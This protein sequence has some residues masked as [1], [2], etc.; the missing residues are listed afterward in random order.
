[1]G[2][3][4]RNDPCTCGSGRKFKQCCGRAARTY[5]DEER[6]NVRN[7]L[8]QIPDQDPDR[9]LEVRNEVFEGI[10]HEDEY[11][12]IEV[13]EWALSW[14]VSEAPS[15][16]AFS[17]DMPPAEA[18]YFDLLY[19]SRASLYE[20]VRVALPQVELRDAFD[21]TRLVVYQPGEDHIEVGHWIAGRVLKGPT[22]LPLV[23]DRPVLGMLPTPPHTPM[24]TY[25]SVQLADIAPEAARAR[26]AIDLMFVYQLESGYGPSDEGDDGIV[27]Q[28][29]GGGLESTARAVDMTGSI[30]DVTADFVRRVFGEWPDTPME[31]VGGKT[32]RELVETPEGE[33]Q[34]REGLRLLQEQQEEMTQITKRPAPDLGFLWDDLG[35]SR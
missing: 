20:V 9:Y 6:R 7:A 22:G 15:P 30:E 8:R 2:K 14:M 11:R 34:V 23:I 12:E 13:Q 3:I 4:G 32:P 16:L 27:A 21:D 1:M 33:A 18:R 5:S 10:W 35:L 28:M 19:R 29:V 24:D 25:R 26:R 31:D 17:G